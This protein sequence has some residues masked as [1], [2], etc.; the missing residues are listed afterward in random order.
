MTEFGTVA[1][2]GREA[3]FYMSATSPSIKGWAQRPKIFWDPTYAQALWH[4]AMKFGTVTH[5]W[6]RSVFLGQSRS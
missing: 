3:Y 1:H 5:V 4:K 2:G 6:P